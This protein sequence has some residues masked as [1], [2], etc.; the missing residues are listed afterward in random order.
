MRTIISGTSVRLPTRPMLKP[1]GGGWRP[2]RVAMESVL[3]RTKR[4]RRII[5]RICCSRVC[6]VAVHLFS[7]D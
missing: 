7:S 2:V 4:G 1:V 3:E 5:R 6:V